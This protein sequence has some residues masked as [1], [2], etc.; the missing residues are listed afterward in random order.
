MSDNKIQLE[1]LYEEGDH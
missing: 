1:N